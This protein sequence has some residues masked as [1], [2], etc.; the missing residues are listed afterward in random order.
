MKCLNAVQLLGHLGK[1]P[2]LKYTAS[3]DAVCT[4]SVA[5]SVKWK[6]KNS[7]EDK[8]RVDWHRVVVWKGLAEAVAN[9]LDKGSAVHVSGELRYNEYEKNGVKVKQ[10]EVVATDVIFLPSGAR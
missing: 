7:G 9:Y 6:D 4:I 10:A 8:E 2:E 3:G 1:E 5:T